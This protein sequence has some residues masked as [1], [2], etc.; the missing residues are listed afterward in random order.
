MELRSIRAPIIAIVIFEAL[1]LFA[2][3][4]ARRQLLDS[5]YASDYAK[6][7]SYL[8]VPIVL[9]LLMWPILRQQWPHI[10]HIFRFDALTAK[11]VISGVLVG[12]LLRIAWWAQLA[13]RISFGMTGTDNTNRVIGPLFHFNCPPPAVLLLGLVVT[14][15]LIPIIEETV[16]RGLLLSA[17]LHRGRLAAI[18][19]STLIFT[20]AHNPSSYVAVYLM[21]LVLAVQYTM[22]G[23]LW[24]SIA[25]HATYNGLI[26]FDWYCINGQWNPPAAQLP[27]LPVGLSALIVLL[28]AFASICL[29]LRANRT[30][31]P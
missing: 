9:G 12:L 25:T 16:H 27:L 2:R 30:G 24:F 3:E 21:G 28:V 20:V 22:P 18:I 10:R 29:V 26:Q 5:G 23:A 31:A 19:L 4:F 15:V 1:A 17:L 8:V 7:L 6:D 11:I 13:T 14:A